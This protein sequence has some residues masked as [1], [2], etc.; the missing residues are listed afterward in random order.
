MVNVLE[1]KDNKSKT[2][3]INKLAKVADDFSRKYTKMK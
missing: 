2:E 3:A 1:A